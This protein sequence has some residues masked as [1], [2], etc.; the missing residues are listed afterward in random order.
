MATVAFHDHHNFRP[1]D[2]KHI[3]DVWEREQA[4][5]GIAQ[6]VSIVCTEKD[7]VRLMDLEPKLDDELAERI[8]YLPIT[9]E[10][11][12]KPEDF[13]KMILQAAKALPPSLQRMS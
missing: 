10:I 5:A 12:F 4:F 11:L 13:R 7:A 2:L 1:S 3:R 8:F 6:S 9:T